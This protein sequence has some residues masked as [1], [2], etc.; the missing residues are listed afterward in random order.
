MNSNP[1]DQNPFDLLGEL[2][3]FG[4]EHSI[5]LNDPEAIPKFA[6]FVGNAL[7]R[8]LSNPALLHGHR[9]EAIFEALLVSPNP[10]KDTD[11]RREESG[12]GG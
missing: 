5:P 9:V 10:P 8:A 1:S 3:K 4:I 7:G 2:A 11:G 12:R 6:T